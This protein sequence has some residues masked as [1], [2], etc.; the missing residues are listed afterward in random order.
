MSKLDNCF[1][2]NDLRSG[3]VTNV[4]IDGDPKSVEESLAIDASKLFTVRSKEGIIAALQL[5]NVVPTSVANKGVI[6]NSQTEDISGPESPDGELSMVSFHF[7]HI[8]DEN[9]NPAGT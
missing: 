3:R 7:S 8:V 5:G 4:I 2:I 6:S 1:K 9:G